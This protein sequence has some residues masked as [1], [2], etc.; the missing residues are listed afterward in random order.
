MGICGHTR[1]VLWLCTF[2]IPGAIAAPAAAQQPVIGEPRAVAVTGGID[3][4]NRYVFRGIPQNA[5]KIALWPFVDIDLR[6]Y[7]GD[8]V[9]KH[10]GVRA[11]VWSSLHTGD[12]GA[13]GP[14]RSL[15]Y[16]T[17]YY[18]GVELGLGRGIEV[19]ALFTAYT[20]P[21]DMFTTIKE[22]SVKVSVDER[23]TLGTTLAPYAF[24]AFELDTAVGVGQADGGEK[25]GAYMEAGIAPGVRISRVELALPVRVGI[26][27]DDYYELA[28]EDHAFG[29][30]SIGGVVS[31]PIFATTKPDRL[32]VRGGVEYQTLGDTTRAFNGGKRSKTVGQIG[33]RFAY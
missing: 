29:F 9:F 4:G 17:D 31:V 19:G 5:T 10:V 8:G 7:V 14:A 2:A 27:L 33:L 13:D 30:L 28:R 24:A 21:N 23:S 3:L 22:V 11:G 20:S 25:G 15:R 26:S 6:P 16:E 32:S 12:T 1:F 18:A